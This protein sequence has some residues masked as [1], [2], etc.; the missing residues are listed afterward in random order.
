MFVFFVNFNQKKGNFMRMTL[1]AS[2]VFFFSCSFMYN[3]DLRKFKWKNRIL[4]IDDKKANTIDEKI[5]KH[6]SLEFEDRDLLIIKVIDNKVFMNDSLASHSLKESVLSII[7]KQAGNNNM[8]LI[9]KDGKVKH[10][11][12]FNHEIG[13]ILDDIDSMPMRIRE[14]NE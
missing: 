9:G 14:M 1:V 5:K 10:K 11:Y 12:F 6:Y 2:L 13:Q 7:D 8:I 4:I 3:E